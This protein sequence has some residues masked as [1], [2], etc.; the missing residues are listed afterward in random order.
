MNLAPLRQQLAEA[1]NGVG[2]LRAYDYPPSQ[3]TPPA[4]VVE[5]EEVDFRA[6]P[7]GGFQRGG[8][9]WRMSVFVLIAPVD[10]EQAARQVDEFFD[11]SAGDLK[12]RLD[13][14]NEPSVEVASA[15]R[16]GEYNL[17]G[18]VYAGVRF[19]VEVLG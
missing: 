14:I 13:A 19:V 2:G 5:P 4:A 18:S 11:R 16:W 15:D 12:D 6:R 9:V 17:A 8:E 10:A 7:G 3:I 1:I